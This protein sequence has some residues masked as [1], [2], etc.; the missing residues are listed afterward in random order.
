MGL[1]TL[2]PPPLLQ[3]PPRLSV[4]AGLGLELGLGL[5]LGLGCC[6]V[7]LRLKVKD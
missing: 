3:N 1:A 2:T 4:C 5:G 6:L 7:G